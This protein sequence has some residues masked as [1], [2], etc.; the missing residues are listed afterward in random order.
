MPPVTL[1]NP[2]PDLSS[3]PT[4]RYGNSYEFRVRLV[5]LTG[6]GPIVTDSVVHPGPV[7]TSQVTFLRHVP[8]KSLEV[9]ASPAW[10]SFP[11]CRR[12]QDRLPFAP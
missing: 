1:P 8:P 11:N 2:N 12:R 4:L 7:P 3:V 5:D 9:V 6:G 10:P